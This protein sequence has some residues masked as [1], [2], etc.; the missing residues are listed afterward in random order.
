MEGHQ[1][2][3]NYKG[4]LKDLEKESFPGYASFFFCGIEMVFWL[5]PKTYQL[6]EIFSLKMDGCVLVKT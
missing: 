3:R 4:R 6:T 1:N 5:M 2:I